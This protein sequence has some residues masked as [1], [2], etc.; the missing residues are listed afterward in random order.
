[1]LQ[2]RCSRKGFRVSGFSFL[3][4]EGVGLLYGS[5]F[6]KC[7]RVYLGLRICCL[8]KLSGRKTCCPEHRSLAVSVSTCLLF[9]I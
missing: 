2:V 1:M 6:V 4:V 3:R 8:F 7:Y 5:G 9:L